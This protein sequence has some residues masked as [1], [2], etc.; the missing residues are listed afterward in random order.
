M[1]APEGQPAPGAISPLVAVYCGDST[2]KGRA[3]LHLS[4]AMI[5]GG[6]QATS[7]CRSVVPLPSSPMPCQKTSSGAA[8]EPSYPGG[9]Y[10]R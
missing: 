10:S 3:A 2:M 4:F 7:F 1:V 5:F 8:L 9:R 6:P